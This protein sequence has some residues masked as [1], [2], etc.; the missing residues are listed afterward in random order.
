MF[1]NYFAIIKCDFLFAVVY[2]KIPQNYSKNRLYCD[3]IATDDKID[4]VNFLLLQQTSRKVRLYTSIDMV[5][6]IAD[7]FLNVSVF[8]NALDLPNPDT[9]HLDEAC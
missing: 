5:L 6:D 8:F 2:V 9:Q 4:E 7:A 1:G 3:C